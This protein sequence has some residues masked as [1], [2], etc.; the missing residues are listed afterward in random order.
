LENGFLIPGS[1]PYRPNSVPRE[2]GAT[3]RTP[4]PQNGLHPPN[5]D[6]RS[7]GVT[8][9]SSGPELTR[10]VSLEAEPSTSPAIG[11][12]RQ[13][14]KER[15]VPTG[16]D[17]DSVPIAGSSRSAGA[18]SGSGTSGGDETTTFAMRH[19]PQLPV[20]SFDE[21]VYSRHSRQQE[22]DDDAEDLEMNAIAGNSSRGLGMRRVL[23]N[24]LSDAGALLFG[25]GSSGGGGGS[26]SG[27]RNGS[28]R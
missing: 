27:G 7:S 5:R 23:K 15:E 16:S 18:G 21:P 9:P 14:G 1:T 19:A 22:S 20:P 4:V 26:G 11:Y 25:R 2:S 10:T 28:S 3:S 12:R 24:T 6:G 13:S 8:T 17:S